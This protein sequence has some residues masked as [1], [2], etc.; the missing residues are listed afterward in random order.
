[1]TGVLRL[2]RVSSAF[3]A[4]ANMWFV[5]LWTR[6]MDEE[7]GIGPTVDYPLWIP[8]A[9][10]AVAGAG[11][12][13][14]GT[15]LNDVLDASRDRV[16]QRDRPI[17]SGQITPETAVLTTGVTLAIAVLGSSVFGAGGVVL[18]TLAALGVLIFN[19]AGKH[20][21]GIGMLTL[22]VIYAAHMLVPNPELRFLWPVWLVMT[23]ALGVGAAAHIVGRKR[24]RLSLRA[25]VFAVIGWIFASGVLLW[26]G[27]RRSAGMNGGHERAVWPEWVPLSAAIAPA[28]LAVWFVIFVTSRVRATGIGPRSA[29]KLHRYGAV[30]LLLYAAAWLLGVGAWKTGLA[31]AGLAALAIVGT[32]VLRELYM[33]IE[34]PA[35]FQR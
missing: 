16:F 29:E 35:G 19:A 8:L 9:G 21:P 22:G 32:T 27:L 17:T 20:V 1:M 15:C 12:Y 2:S 5:I 4:V 18:T 26:L 33:L 23:H 6:A 24:P 34:Q 30:W 25:F 3:A 14:F 28:L 7:Q 31:M 10:G 11:L 13:A